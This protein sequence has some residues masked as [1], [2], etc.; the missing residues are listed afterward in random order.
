[1]GNDVPMN[2]AVVWALAMALSLPVGALADTTQAPQPPPPSP[3]PT[4]PTPPAAG[5]APADPNAAA[6]KPTQPKPPPRRGINDQR[7]TMRSYPANLGYNMYGV[8]TRGNWL[9]LAVGAGLTGGALLLDDEVQ[10]Y[11]VRKDFTGFGDAGAIA[12][13][14]IAVAGLTLGAFSAGRIARGD[15]F[16]A[17]TYDMSQAIIVDGIWTA[18]IKLAAG[19]ERPNMENNKSFPSGHASVAFS[20]ATVIGRHYGLKG[21]IPAYTVATFIATSRMAKNAHWF[22]DVVAGS[23]LGFGIGRAVV[24]RNSRPPTPPGGPTPP[25]PEKPSGLELGPDFGPAA[26][27]LG[28]QLRL[29]F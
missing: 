13:G 3:A 21:G 12:G 23:A 9:P 17:C 15:R 20:W 1:M 19:R 18:A 28:L 2:R 14:T 6:Q 25:Q 26:D 24:R 11:F 4:E 27:G 5:S 7:R 10:D 22:S 8:V 29:Q 16:R